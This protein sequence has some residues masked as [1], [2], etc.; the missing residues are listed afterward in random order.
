MPSQISASSTEVKGPRKRHRTPPLSPLPPLRRRRHS[1][2]RRCRRRHFR[3]AK[4]RPRRFYSN[5]APP[6]LSRAPIANSAPPLCAILPSSA[7]PPRA[8]SGGERPPRAIY[9]GEQPPWPKL[10]LT[11]KARRRPFVVLAP[12]CCRAERKQMSSSFRLCSVCKW[13]RGAHL[14]ICC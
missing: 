11:A 7:P 3:R 1:L 8:T 2:H 5:G 6:K 12:R 4:H 9:G 13:L 10:P 14:E